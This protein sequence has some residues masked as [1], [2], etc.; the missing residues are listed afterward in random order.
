M[1]FL[2][3]LCGLLAISSGMPEYDDVVDQICGSHPL[4][5]IVKKIETAREYQ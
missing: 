1:R 2:L 4:K 3:W 5:T